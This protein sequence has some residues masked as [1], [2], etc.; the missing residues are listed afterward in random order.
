MDQF[1]KKEQKFLDDYVI[2]KLS[3]EGVYFSEYT[4]KELMNVTREPYTSSYGNEPTTKEWIEYNTQVLKNYIES[5]G[6]NCYD[7]SDTAELYEEA[8]KALEVKRRM[9][10]KEEIYQYVL[11]TE[12]IRGKEVVTETAW[13]G[14]PTKKEKKRWMEENKN[15]KG[16]YHGNIGWTKLWPVTVTK[17]KVM[18]RKEIEEE[19]LNEYGY[20]LELFLSF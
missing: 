15:C 17:E 11:T 6:Y 20:S 16:K 7:A 9:F 12:N 1:T 5:I 10:P 13:A 4:F 8:I 2:S 14:N 19:F 3:Q 18:T